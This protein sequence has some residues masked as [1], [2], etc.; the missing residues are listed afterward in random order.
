MRCGRRD[1][2]DRKPL[3]R[4]SDS[5]HAGDLARSA[6]PGGDLEHP[7]D[8]GCVRW[9]AVD[10]Q[11]GPNRAPSQ[12]Q[13]RGGERLCIG[14]VDGPGELVEQSVVVAEQV[15]G[16]NQ[17]RDDIAPGDG[18]DQR[19][20]LM[21]NPVAPE[22]RVGVRRVLHRI[23]VQGG[24]EQVR[25]VAAQPE[26]RAVRTGS[27]RRQARRAA[28][29]EQ[30][31]QHRFRLVVGRVAGERVGPEQLVASCSGP[32]LEV[33]AVVEFGAA[34]AKRHPETIGDPLRSVGLVVRLLADPMVNVDSDDIEVRGDGKG[35]QRAGVGP[36]G[37]AAGDGGARRREGAAGEELAREPA[38]IGSQRSWWRRWRLPLGCCLASTLNM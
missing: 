35:E 19:Q 26:E 16:A 38:R 30:C 15:G 31:Q 36:P 22:T 21:A 10:A 20:E 27:H 6:G 24:A 7:R 9:V 23:E 1:R 14:R 34:A 17:E 4:S 8:G 18:I 2:F 5:A 25:F 13:W 33:R 37:K 32:G 29:A 28:S 11:P 12:R 3:V